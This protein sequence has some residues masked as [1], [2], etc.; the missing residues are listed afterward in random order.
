[1]AFEE[2]G[3]YDGGGDEAKLFRLAAQ[4]EQTRPWKDKMP[5]VCA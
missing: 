1:M 4:I 3:D 5:P 2:Y